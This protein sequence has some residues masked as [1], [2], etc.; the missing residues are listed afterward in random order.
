MRFRCETI[1]TAYHLSAYADGIST[2][3]ALK[4]TYLFHA[5]VVPADNG[6]CFLYGLDE[7]LTRSQY[8]ALFNELRLMRFTE[9]AWLHGGGVRRVEL[10]G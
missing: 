8:Q 7:T 10:T 9:A 2:G 1:F 5:L 4:T 3:R 6:G